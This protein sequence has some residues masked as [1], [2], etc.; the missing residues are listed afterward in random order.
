MK[1]SGLIYMLLLAVLFACQSVAADGYRKNQRYET[2]YE[3]TLENAVDRAKQQ[4]NGRVISAE[5]DKKDGRNTHKIR[6][7]TDDGHVRRL[8]VDEATGEYIRPSRR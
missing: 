4:Y 5:T 1:V 2:A 8:R 6:I 3:M 7:L